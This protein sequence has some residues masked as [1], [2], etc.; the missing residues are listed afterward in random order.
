MNGISN[1]G[2]ETIIYG[3][4]RESASVPRRRAHANDQL[5]SQLGQ[6]LGAKRHYRGKHLALSTAARNIYRLQS[7]AELTHSC[8]IFNQ[9]FPMNKVE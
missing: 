6:V 7:Q 3:N 8:N 1:W 5:L 2:P 9:L 4:A